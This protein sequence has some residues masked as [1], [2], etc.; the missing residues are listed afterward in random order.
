M[1][2]DHHLNKKKLQ[3]PQV[4]SWENLKK[5]NPWL[6]P[7]EDDVKKLFNVRSIPRLDRYAQKL[8][9]QHEEK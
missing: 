6:G 9:D 8:V 4:V 1:K 3:I 7:V 2:V 5:A